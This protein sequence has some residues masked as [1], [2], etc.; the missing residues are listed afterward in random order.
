MRL[1]RAAAAR[2][3]RLAFT[4]VPAFT[5]GAILCTAA[6]PALNGGWTLGALLMLAAIGGV[7]LD[8]E[9]R[10]TEQPAETVQLSPWLEHRLVPEPVSEQEWLGNDTPQ[11]RDPKFAQAFDDA[12]DSYDACGIALDDGDLAAAKHNALNLVGRITRL[13]ALDAVKGAVR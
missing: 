5:V 8:L 4:Y 12:H 6:G 2:R 3:R 11:G 1:P 13:Q 7:L 9:P 10:M